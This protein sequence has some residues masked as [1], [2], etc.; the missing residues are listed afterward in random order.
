MG[1]VFHF[2]QRI[3]TRH[4]IFVFYDTQIEYVEFYFLPLLALFDNF[5]AKIGQNGLKNEKHILQMCVRISFKKFFQ[6]GRLHFEF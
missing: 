4:R 1:D 3:Q 6:A 2:F 5:K